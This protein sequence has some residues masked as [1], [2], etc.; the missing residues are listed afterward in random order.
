MAT[1]VIERKRVRT[2]AGMNRPRGRPRG[3]VA[4]PDRRERWALAAR[5]YVAADMSTSDFT[6]SLLRW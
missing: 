3:A 2:S 1:S 6:A 5:D 4:D